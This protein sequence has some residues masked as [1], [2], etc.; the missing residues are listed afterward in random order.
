MAKSR[1]GQIAAGFLGLRQSDRRAE[2]VSSPADGERRSGEDRRYNDGPG[3]PHGVLFSTASSIEPVQA[4][5]EESCREAWSL[6]LEDLDTVTGT[7]KLRLLFES[8]QDKTA[9][10]DRFS[11]M[12]APGGE[13]PAEN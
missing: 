8:R 4:W 2:E 7:K 3:K 5:L 13:P 1:L 11:C 9:F 10:I 6:R 12:V